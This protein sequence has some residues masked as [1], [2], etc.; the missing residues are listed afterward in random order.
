MTA[1]S[2]T[3]KLISSILIISIILPAV[4]FSTPKQAQALTFFEAGGSG[5]WTKITSVFSGSTA[6]S[7]AISASNSIRQWALE[8]Y[9]QST[10]VLAKRLLAK[11]TQDT[12]D[13][14]NSGFH[15]SP[16]FLENPDSFF[17]DIAKSQ[18]RLLVDMI[19]YD[20]FR[21]PFGRETALNVINSYK[22]QFEINAQYTLSKVINDP[23]LLVRYRNDFNYGGWNGFLVNTQYPQNN[24]L[25]FEGLVQQNLASRLQGTL[26][27]PAQ[28]VQNAL[29]QGMGFLSPQTCPTNENYNKGFNE[30]N[31]PTFKYN[32]P[33]NPPE[34]NEYDNAAR[35]AYD[36][37][38]ESDKAAAHAAWSDPKGPNVCPGGL[39]TTTPGS[40]A[41]SRVMAGINSDFLS[42]ALDGAIGNSLAAIFDALINKLFDTGLSAMSNAIRPAP[43]A[44]NWSYNGNTLSGGYAGGTNVVETTLDIPQNVSMSVGQTTS[45]AISGGTAPYRIQTPPDSTATASISTSGSSGPR[46]SVS[47]VAPGTTSTVV[48][49]SSVPAK[50]VTVAITTNAIGALAAVPASTPTT[51]III[52][53]N[54]PITVTISGGNGN[55]SM[56]TGP[57][58]KVA[59][60]VFSDTIL[61]ITGIASGTTYIE[62]KDSS[63]PSPKTVRVNIR[64]I[65]STEL[66]IS[67]PNVLAF[68]GQTVNTTISGGSGSYNIVGFTGDPESE[69]ARAAFTSPSTLT[70]TG[71]RLGSTSVIIGD[72]SMS[73]KMAT[74]YITVIDPLVVNPGS[75]SVETGTGFARM[76][77][78]NATISG[79]TP[80]YSIKTQPNTSVARAQINGKTLTVVA[81]NTRGSTYVE[82]KDSSTAHPQT[83]NVNITVN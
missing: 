8:V 83:F 47:G 11:I 57:D 48:Q 36:R 55:Y 60:A 5:I 30:F 20:T 17:R 35:E 54:N 28:K 15:G 63:S 72:T 7:A 49:D 3:I 75:L 22:N 46:L 29:Q 23:D 18:I 52:N 4:L 25:G 77:T 69:I 13:W 39:V 64:V 27:A 81:G 41:A 44:D 2:K 82:I 12:V 33:Y 59:V 24:Y 16:L 34:Y 1:K 71:I 40:V 21:F 65:D 45:V 80:P 38:Y 68:T 61:V 73:Q 19:G 67:Q 62:I 50:T 14:I 32:V 56:K 6:G 74:I 58:E 79:G 10:R 31:K 43:P 37:Q 53:P 66:S 51:P 76:T 70:I 26:Q 78:A 42:T 9:R